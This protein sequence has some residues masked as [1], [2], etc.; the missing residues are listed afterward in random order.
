MHVDGDSQ[1]VEGVLTKDMATVVGYL[2][3]WTLKLSTAIAVLVVFHLSNKE[4]KRELKFKHNNKTLPICSEPTY[5][6]VMLDRSLMDTSTP[7]LKSLQH[8]SHSLR[9]LAG[10][11]W[12]AGAITL[13]TASLALVH[14]TAEYSAPVWCRSAHTC[15]ITLPSTRLCKL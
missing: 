13:R 2:Q 14:S 6:G 15:F 7:F 9:G 10:S 3:T 12:G 1:R 8:A 5:L 4:A 11:S